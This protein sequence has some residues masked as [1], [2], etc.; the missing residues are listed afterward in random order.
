MANRDGFFKAINNHL[1]VGIGASAHKAVDHFTERLR[2]HIPNPYMRSGLPVSTLALDLDSGQWRN[3]LLELIHNNQHISAHLGGVFHLVADLN[4]AGAPLAVL[5]LA[6]MLLT[7]PAFDLRQ[8]IGTETDP[9]SGWGGYTCGI[10]LYVIGTDLSN[11]DTN[12]LQNRPSNLA[13]CTFGQEPE[14]NIADLLIDLI[15]CAKDDAIYSDTHFDSVPVRFPTHLRQSYFTACHLVADTLEKMLT[16]AP[17][18]DLGSINELG[19]DDRHLMLDGIMLNGT[20]YSDITDTCYSFTHQ[21]DYRSACHLWDNPLQGMADECET[22]YNNRHISRRYCESNP[23]DLAYNLAHTIGERLTTT[24]INTSARTNTLRFLQDNA[25]NRIADFMRQQESEAANNKDITQRLE[26]T[27]SA[28]QRCNFLQRKRAKRLFGE[29]QDL[30]GRYYETR[31]RGTAS[32]FA[33]QVLQEWQHELERMNEQE[34]LRAKRLND[35]KT[36]I[37]LSTIADLPTADNQTSTDE[38]AA[39]IE[40]PNFDLQQYL[41]LLASN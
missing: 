24:T 37:D 41:L 8:K 5:N 9:W 12:F 27:E 1:I 30:L 33:I 36:T 16:D 38:I 2:Y 10:T 3:T 22:C 32:A 21:N 28:F 39:A 15:F 26:D 29:Y 4:T 11:L 18:I 40:S 20:K 6:K 17:P 23:R 13:I 7:D 25:T 34:Q 19:L 35:I 31:T 14:Q